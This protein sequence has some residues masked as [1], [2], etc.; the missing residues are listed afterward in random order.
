[1]SAS[2]FNLNWSWQVTQ[3]VLLW[4]IGWVD[5]LTDSL[6][7]LISWFIQPFIWISCHFLKYLFLNW[8]NKKAQIKW[9]SNE[10][11][12]TLHGIIWNRTRPRVPVQNQQTR[13]LIGTWKTSHKRQQRHESPTVTLTWHASKYK[14]HKLHQ[15]YILVEFVYLLFTHMPVESYHRCTSWW[16]LCSLYLLVCQWEFTVGNSGLCRDVFVPLFVDCTWYTFFFL[17]GWKCTLNINC[18]VEKTV[19]AVLL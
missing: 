3:T 13:E 11:H 6:T 14:V 2:Q 19:F 15:M 4:L 7:G 8:F 5:L 9:E 10:K 16:R 18:Y 17:N 1:M 12:Q